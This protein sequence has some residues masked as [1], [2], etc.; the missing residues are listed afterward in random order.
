MAS[1]VG[2][3]AP[4]FV[5]IVGRVLPGNKRPDYSSSR[6]RIHVA[7]NWWH[8]FAWILGEIILRRLKYPGI[9]VGAS[10]QY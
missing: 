6:I 5:Q 9:G 4:E 1:R 3:T 8:L 2:M 7:V 10:Q